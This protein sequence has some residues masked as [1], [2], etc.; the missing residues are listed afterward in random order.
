MHRKNRNLSV[1]TIKRIEISN[2]SKEMNVFIDKIDEQ[3]VSGDEVYNCWRQIHGESNK[4]TQKKVSC[5]A[6]HDL[7][8]MSQPFTIAGR[9]PIEKIDCYWGNIGSFRFECLSI[10]NVYFYQIITKCVIW[11][12]KHKN[13]IHFVEKPIIV[14]F[15]FLFQKLLNYEL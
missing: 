14:Y 10:L 12:G 7:I 6:A 13:D 15:V 1:K 2:G 11:C 4:L 8:K 3:S 5:S 9:K